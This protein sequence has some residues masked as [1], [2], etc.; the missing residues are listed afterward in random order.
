MAS[1]VHC[2]SLAHR[3]PPDD[4]RTTFTVVRLGCNVDATKRATHP[5]SRSARPRSF[6]TAAR[7]HR[8]PDTCAVRL[9]GGFAAEFTPTGRRSSRAALSGRHDRAKRVRAQ[10]NEDEWHMIV[11]NSR[12]PSRMV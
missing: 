5:T 9:D 1:C 2:D 7:T 10:W 4:A 8:L 11:T 3:V 6:V 12:S